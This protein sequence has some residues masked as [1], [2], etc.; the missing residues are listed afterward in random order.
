MEAE[1]EAVRQAYAALNRGDIDGFVKDFD[2]NI[3]RIEFEGS[4]M[5][6]KHHGIEAVREHVN[7]GRSTWAEGACEP[8]RFITSGNKVVVTC[9]VRV[10]LK[11]QTDWLEGRTGD[12]FTF[13]NGKVIEFRTFAEEKDAL[14]YAGVDKK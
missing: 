2:P 13:R 6:G 3:E 11:D 5:E 8:D 10:R 9:H 1:I 14:E 12:V 4:P 7:A